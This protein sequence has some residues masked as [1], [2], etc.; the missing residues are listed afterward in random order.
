[1][2]NQVSIFLKIHSGFRTKFYASTYIRQHP[3][4]TKLVLKIYKNICQ[5]IFSS[6]NGLKAGLA[7]GKVKVADFKEK[8]EAIAKALKVPLQVRQS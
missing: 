5:L 6:V 3:K 8:V 7:T 2:T 1:M 4:I